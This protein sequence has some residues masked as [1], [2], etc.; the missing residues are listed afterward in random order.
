MLFRTDDLGEYNDE[1]HDKETAQPNE[2]VDGELFSPCLSDI[3][4]LH[5]P[6]PFDEDIGD[7][8]GQKPDK[9]DPPF[10]AAADNHIIDLDHLFLIATFR[11]LLASFEIAEHVT[12]N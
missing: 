9:E 11:H 8:E 6:K 10:P 4:P 12:R 7:V 1:E 2:Q 5:P 3:F